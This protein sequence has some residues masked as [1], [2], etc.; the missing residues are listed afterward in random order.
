MNEIAN[1]LVQV[2]FKKNSLHDCS[3]WELE[4][5]A[6]KYPYF[7]IA[8]LLVS[9]KL[10]EENKEA[11][12][13]QVQKTSLYFTNPLWLDYL[14]NKKNGEHTQASEKQQEEI[15]IPETKSE[16]PSETI[17]INVPADEAAEHMIAATEP[18]TELIEQAV[19]Q[20]PVEIETALTTK[21]EPVE[22]ST[23]DVEPAAVHVESSEQNKP[24]DVAVTESEATIASLEMA[25]MTSKQEAQASGKT[26][27]TI[28]E[29]TEELKIPSLKT[30]PVDLNAP[31]SF[32]PYH[33]VDYF[34]SQ[35][36]KLSADLKP[37]D[38]FGQQLKSFT[39][40]LKTLK[41]TSPDDLATSKATDQKVISLAEHSIEDRDVITEPMADVWLKQGNKEKAIE[42]YTKLSLQDPAKSSYFAHLIEQL[43]QH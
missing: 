17:E 21:E 22:I 23:S 28:E 2:L 35:G 32:E 16:A 8:Q 29:N 37:Q 27:Q 42:I 31:L 25:E 36:I 11:Y 39:Q 20:Q 24:Q 4:I 19:A 10:K 9:G 14:L 26:A 38:K 43:K 33:T 18:T 13:K 6:D 1:Q 5:L 41:K 7:G 30:E 34:A 40:W 15:S 12:E 3:R